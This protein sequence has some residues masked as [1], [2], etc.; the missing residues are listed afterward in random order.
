MAFLI[1]TDEAGYGPNLGPLLISATMWEVDDFDFE[2]DLYDR[3]S[4]TVTSKP[5]S[6]RQSESIAFCDSKQLYS[7]GATL[8]GLERG[9]L[10][11]LKLLGRDIRDWRECWSFLSP[12]SAAYLDDLPWYSEFN[13]PLPRDCDASVIAELTK[14]LQT[15]FEQ[16]GLKL[17][18]IRSAAVF[19]EPFNERSDELGSKGALLSL[20]T[21]QLVVD[22][23]ERTEGQP[24]FILCDKHGGRSKYSQIIQELIPDVLIEICGESRQQSVYRWGKG[25]SRVEIRFVAKGESFMPSAV[26]SM[27]SK[28]LRELAMMAFNDYWG[29]EVEGVKPTAGYP[30]DAKRFKKDIAARQCE[31]EI[32]DRILWRSR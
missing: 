9:V 2:D 7:S 11:L 20:Q 16:A 5:V 24:T 8:A 13:T 25:E 4:P 32:D 1:G 30:L 19:P 18:Q 21:M 3:L 15:C 23:L 27:A 26:A 10:S 29:H 28:Y 6:T 17:H 31:L 12:E 14:R 22:M